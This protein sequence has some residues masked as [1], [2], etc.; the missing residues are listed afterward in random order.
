MTKLRNY[1]LKRFFKSIF[2]NRNGDRI[3]TQTNYYSRAMVLNQG[4]PSSGTF[5]NSWRHFWF[6]TRGRTANGLR[7]TG[8]WWVEVRDAGLCNILHG[9][10]QVPH[11]ESSS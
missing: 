9:T 2:T 10:G 3:K 7:A 6:M 1:N 5:V 11:R 4:C 8:I